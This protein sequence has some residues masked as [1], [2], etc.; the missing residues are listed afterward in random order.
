MPPKLT[1]Q[2]RG[3]LTCGKPAHPVTLNPDGSPQV[4]VVWIG[5]EGD[6]IVC[7]HIGEWRKIRNIRRD[8]RVALSIET[9]Q[10]HLA[11]LDGYLAIIGMARI[12][13]GGAPQLLRRLAAVYLGPGTEL[14]WTREPPPG[15]VTYITA[16]R[17]IRP[18]PPNRYEPTPASPARADEQ[19]VSP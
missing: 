12:S 5:L 16:E 8:P 17:I 3:I 14:P 18:D 7:A 11:G 9:G 13:Q 19:A 1:E 4:S 10:P 15:H 6:E 2:V